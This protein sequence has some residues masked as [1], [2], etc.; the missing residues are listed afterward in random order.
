MYEKEFSKRL[1]QLRIRRNVS[2]REMSLSLGQ[3]SSYINHIENGQTLPSMRG[4]F[5]ICDYLGI[6]PSEFFEFDVRYPDCCSSIMESI[7]ELDEQEVESLEK[8][9]TILTEKRHK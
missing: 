1:S 8:L 9:L 3:N 5:Y 2:A 6:S 7:K 4:F